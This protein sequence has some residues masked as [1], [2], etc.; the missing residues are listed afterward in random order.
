MTLP[1]LLILISIC[2]F[3]AY[4]IFVFTKFGIPENLSSTYYDAEKLHRH[5][6]LLFPLLMLTLCFTLF[7]S[8]QL[9][10]HSMPSLVQRFNWM[11]YSAVGSILMM[12]IVTNYRKSLIHTVIHYAAAIYTAVAVICWILIADYTLF[13]VPLIVAFLIS[14]AGVL[15][16]TFVSRFS[17][18]LELATIYTIQFSFF[19]FSI[20]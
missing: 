9:L 12:A 19:I 5:L 4:N 6:G 8:W 17:F 3:A 16:H 7:P 13:Y 2:C 1:T 10:E 20:R 11:I 14:L 15:T 18:W